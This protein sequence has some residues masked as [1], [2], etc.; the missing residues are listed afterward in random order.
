MPVPPRKR[1]QWLPLVAAPEV[2]VLA[3]E[4]NA[5]VVTV[6]QSF[7][8]ITVHGWSFGGNRTC[9]PALTNTSFRIT[10]VTGVSQLRSRASDGVSFQK[11][12][13]PRF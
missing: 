7:T 4:A 8:G 13:F 3:G 11:L 1:V 2:F 10:L 9:A 6:R 5:Q 12:P